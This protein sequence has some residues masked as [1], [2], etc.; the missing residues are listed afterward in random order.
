VVVAKVL[1]SS[2]KA[3]GIKRLVRVNPRTATKE[4]LEG[5]LRAAL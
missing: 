5:I 3:L 2:C 4:D 1:T